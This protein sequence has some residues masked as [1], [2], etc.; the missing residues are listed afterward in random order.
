MSHSIR[1]R[2][3]LK[4]GVLAGAGL[5][6]T[7]GVAQAK[8]LER[9]G[10]PNEKLNIAVIGVGHRGGANRNGVKSENIVALCDVDSRFIGPAAKAHPK[11][12]QYKDWRKALEQ[13]DIDAVVCSTTDHTH[14]FISKAAMDLGKHVYCEKPLAHSV[15]EARIVRETYLKNKDKIATQQGTQI[16]ATDNYRRVVELIRCGAIGKVTEA[17]VW[18]NRAAPGK[19]WPKKPDPVPSTL[20]WDLW[21][22]PAP[23][24]PFSHEVLPASGKWNCLSWNCWWDYGQNT[25]GDMGS[26][27]IDL[28]YWALDLDTPTSCEAKADP[29]PADPVACSKWL[30]S[31]W[32]HPA[33][34]DRGPIKLVW[35]DADKRPKSP[36]GIDLTQWGI[37]VMFHGNKGTLVADYGVHYL[38]PKRDY[39]GFVVPKMEIPKSRGHYQEWLHAC[40]TG[41]PTLCN[42]DYAGM[43]IEN[44]L[45]A[46]VAYR[47]G[48]KLE[49]DAKTGK[50][51]NCPQA[52]QYIQREYRKGWTL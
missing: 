1:R 22:G 9:R 15:S 33:K 48:K 13:K 12:K 28:A 44:N 3:F 7:G 36:K 20:D 24:R 26:H 18:C 11:A 16:H 5:S 17:H 46:N 40:K 35:Y 49:Y 41:A 31:T 37:G 14:A 6:M 47:V 23:F 50:A 39:R 19:P 27:L 10:S 8:K 29:W 32:Q 43:L 30:I 34:G 45:L 38:L 25:I 51:V 4:S 52:D 42:F 2:D 21:V